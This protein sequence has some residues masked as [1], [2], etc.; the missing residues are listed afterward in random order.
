MVDFWSILGGARG[1][2]ELGFGVQVASWDQVGP[3]IL[4]KSSQDSPKSMFGRFFCRF[5]MIFNRF[6]VDFWSILSRFLVDFWSI[7]RLM[8]SKRHF[9]SH[10]S[11]SSLTRQM[12]GLYTHGHPTYMHT[13]IHDGL[14]HY[15]ID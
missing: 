4:S 3:K 10:M 7:D 1:S 2:N 14:M 13:C 15:W 5:L 9:P 12:P 11:V 6:V 8:M